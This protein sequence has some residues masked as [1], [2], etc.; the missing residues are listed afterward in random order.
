M[1]PFEAGR[2]ETVASLA[3]SEEQ[4]PRSSSLR[5]RFVEFRNIEA[6]NPPATAVV[7]GAAQC[8][9][10]AVARIPSSS[11]GAGN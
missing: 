4:K 9:R 2:E 11:S 7:E 10:A 1:A 8:S 6:G 5:N 3:E